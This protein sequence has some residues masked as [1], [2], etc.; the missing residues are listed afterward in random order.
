MERT[1]RLVIAA[2]TWPAAALLAFCVAP[3]LVLFAYS[4]FRVDFV[5]IVPDPSLANLL[6]LLGLMGAAAA[7]MARSPAARAWRG[8]DVRQGEGLCP[9]TPPKAEPLESIYMVSK[10]LRPL[11]A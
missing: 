1:R 3:L 9:S 10:G 11:A 8:A 5:T 6:G 7:A 4:F 2:L